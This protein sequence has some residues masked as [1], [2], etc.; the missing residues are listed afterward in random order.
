[1][2]NDLHVIESIPAYALECL[3]ENEMHAV[4]AHLETC[5]SCRAELRAYSEV[6]EKIAMSVPQV[7]PPARVKSALMASV[8][9]ALP[10]QMDFEKRESGKERSRKGFFGLSPAWLLAGSFLILLLGASNLLLWQQVREL[11]E[12]QPQFEMIS[13]LGTGAAPGATGMIVISLEGTHGTLVVDNLPPLE[14]D[15]QFQLWLVR[16]SQRASGGVFSVDEDGYGSVWVSSP[17]PLASYTGFGITIEPAG[18]SAGPTGE[19][20]LG[21]DL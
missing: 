18:G 11:R 14:E 2:L 3:D 1:M 19:K 12:N 9:A 6:S 15:Q 21:N 17:E 8:R 16:D 10:S 20:V 13:L 5:E 4:S 7:E